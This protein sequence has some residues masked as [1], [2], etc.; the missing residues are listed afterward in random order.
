MS[1][2]SVYELLF[3]R[4]NDCVAVYKAVNKGKDFIF[5]DFNPAAERAENIKK[6]ELLGKKVTEVFPGIKEFGL[7]KVFQEVYKTG[8]PRRFPLTFYKDKRITGWRDNDVYKI[9][10][11]HIVA[12]YHDLTRQKQ[13]EEQLFLSARV[14][15]SAKEGIIITDNDSII[16]Q[17]NEAYV[18]LSGYRREEMIGKKATFMKSNLYPQKF[19]D[20][21]WKKLMEE[22][23]WEGEI[24]DRNREG[25][26]I[27]LYLMIS[28]VKNSS[29]DTT[30]YIGIYLDI[31]EQKQAQDH[32]N[33][34]AYFDALTNL[35]NRTFFLQ[36]LQTLSDQAARLNSTLALLFLDLD[37]F[38]NINDTYGHNIGDL[39]LIEVGRRIKEKSRKSDFIARLGGDEFTVII[40]NI[41]TP[42]IAAQLAGELIETLSSSYVIEGITIHTTVSIGIAVFPN[43]GENPHTLLKNADTAMY[44][45]KRSGKNRFS[46]FRAE[47]N[48]LIRSRIELDT[49][50]RKAVEL[51][52]LS[53][54]YQPKICLSSGR[55]DGFEALLRWQHPEKGFISPEKFIPVAEQSN[56]ILSLGQWVF[57]Q[58]CIFQKKLESLNY[59][60]SISIN[61]SSKQLYDDSF[62]NNVLKI[63]ERLKADPSRLEIEITESILMKNIEKSIQ[64]LLFLKE[65]GFHI[66]IDDFGTGYSSMNYLIKLPID[67]IKIDKSFILG[68]KE[69]E[70]AQS[71]VKA[72]IA[73]AKSLSLQTVAEGVETASQVEFLKSVDCNLAQGFYYS[74]PI[75]QDEVLGYL[76]GLTAESINKI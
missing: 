61:V 43:D 64:K 63:T 57:E 38:K 29:G 7:F 17:V 35:G 15:E 40:T 33:K 6:E 9:D 71:I 59:M 58:A 68:Q 60:V 54:F 36:E 10:D 5:V 39:L 48:E 55:L 20:Q 28:A 13:Y 42:E 16:V 51:K 32:I 8:E 30:H 23:H 21:M 56:L 41:K 11:E 34:L 46:F 73:L 31:T 1:T 19:Y 62:C 27:A 52:Q 44:N 53:L 25:K 76:K 4:I 47:M 14:F 37:N 69:Q 22:G 18:Q 66:S 67:A 70:G 74:R 24:W 50:L 45:S 49:D 72:I 12:V 26:F 65:Q 2:E 3:N 75:P